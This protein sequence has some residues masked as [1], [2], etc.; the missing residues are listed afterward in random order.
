[1]STKGTIV[2]WND[3][4]GFG[5][6]EP[7]GGGARVFCHINAFSVRVR[8][9]QA[10]DAVTY[11]ATKDTKGRL[12]ASDVRP[13]GLERAAYSGNGGRSRKGA[14][15][16]S[17]DAPRQPNAASY[18]FIVVFAASLVALVAANRISMFVPLIYIAMTGITLFAY[19]F[20][21]SAAMNNRW[22]TP[23]STLHV[24]ALAGGWPGGLIAQKALRHKS[25]KTSFRVTF[26]F[27]VILNVLALATHSRLISSLL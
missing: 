2:E 17:S 25:S 13:L 12:Q 14:R 10:G 21:K 19:A 22:R 18:L 3:D 9:P 11:R 23:E 16:P 7:H 8:R 24:L 4:R 6:I 26:W 15:K 5:F 1:M 20:D 27:C